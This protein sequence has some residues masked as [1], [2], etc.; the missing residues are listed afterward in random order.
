MLAN[1]SHFRRIRIT[2]AVNLIKIGF[3][4]SVMIVKP[5]IAL[6]SVCLL[7]F[8]IPIS[9]VQF[10][11]AN[12][13]DFGVYTK[14]TTPLNIPYDIWVAMF[15]NWDASLLNK[16]GTTSCCEGLE[17]NGCLMG[18]VGPAVILLNTAIGGSKTQNCNIKSDQGIFVQ[19]WSGECE[20]VTKGLERGTYDQILKC[21][22][23]LDLGTVKGKVIVDGTVVAELDAK[24]L[25][26]NKLLNVVELNTPFFSLTFPSGSHLF[27]ARPGT[28]P[29]VAHGWFVFLKPL[30]LGDHTV[31]YN[32]NVLTVGT[33]LGGTQSTAQ[34]T[35]HFKVT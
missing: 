26:S 21:A 3:D 22:R 30:P 12:G 11:T 9:Y 25:A 17:D 7:V 2:D 20:T 18:D 1:K 4:M 19:L 35:Y 13:A 34:Y 5:R 29:A 33:T 32:I 14:D 31:T 24:D 8:L 28:F 6:I 16:P 10:P 27:A 15:W 23:D